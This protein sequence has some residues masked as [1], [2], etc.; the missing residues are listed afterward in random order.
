[1][2]VIIASSISN[3]TGVIVGRKLRQFDPRLGCVVVDQN[4]TCHSDRMALA[5]LEYLCCDIFSHV[6]CKVSRSSGFCKIP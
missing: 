3:H 1:M 4:E 2:I 5:A 6:V